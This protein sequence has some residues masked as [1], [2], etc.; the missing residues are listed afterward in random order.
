MS[1]PGYH[2]VSALQA[3]DSRWLQ[4]EV[5][6]EFQRNKCSRSD[7]ECK[8]AHPVPHVEV[9]NGKVTACFD[10]IKGRCNREKPPCKY[11]HPPQH[12]KEQLLINGKN[13]LAFKNAL[14]QQLAA[15]G[16]ALHATAPMASPAGQMYAGLSQYY[17]LAASPPVGD[18]AMVAS[19]PMQQMQQKLPTDRL[20]SVR[21]RR[22]CRGTPPTELGPSGGASAAD[23]RRP[24]TGEPPELQQR[25]VCATP[26]RQRFRV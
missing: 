23:R 14:M 12:L 10:S 24:P 6:R 15:G 4:L 25:P 3:K 5:C 13:N 17:T 20:E 18:T 16:L 19:L 26:C 1:V 8:F 7:A 11:F 21:R 22:V 9:Q 2:M